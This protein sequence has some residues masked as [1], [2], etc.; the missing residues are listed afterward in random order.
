MK[1]E[2]S[3]ALVTGGAGFVGSHLAEVLVNE[4][5]K[6]RI[7]DNLSTGFKENIS[8]LL[9][10]DKVDFICGDIRDWKVCL[11][12]TKGI[13]VVFHQAAQ[14]NPVRAVEDPLYDFDVNARGT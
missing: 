9:T 11:E 10:V 1:L 12:A 4:G 6:V 8:Q 13:D 5:C 7:L 14:I 2:G 3:N